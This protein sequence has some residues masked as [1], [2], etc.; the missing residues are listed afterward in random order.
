MSESTD[1]ELRLK[2]TELFV[3]KQ[4]L[5]ELERSD[6]QDLYIE[7]LPLNDIA[8]GKLV[9]RDYLYQ[10]MGLQR[11]AE[12]SLIRI[13]DANKF[14]GPGIHVHIVD[15]PAFK[16]FYV[17]LFESIPSIGYGA[18]IVYSRKTGTGK[19]NGKPF[20]LNRNSRN[21]KLF[22]YI[23]KRP[24]EYI[25][26]EKLWI[27]A[28]EKRKFTENSDQVIE[29]NSFITTLREALK[30]IGPEHLRLKKRVILDAE[31]TLTD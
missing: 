13:L 29:F 24:N 30:N 15:V 3:T 26:K 21:R 2:Q 31:V 1:Q 23:A 28:G 22:A 11:L 27:V 5:D 9:S 25:T 19:I 7:P 18:R 14:M 20:K 10:Q 16:T 6:G 4:I 17:E 8:S 12:K